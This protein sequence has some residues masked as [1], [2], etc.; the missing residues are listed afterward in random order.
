MSELIRVRKVGSLWPDG[1]FEMC[2]LEGGPFNEK[3]FYY[4]TKEQLEMAY[5]E[6]GKALMKKQGLGKSK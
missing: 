1:M 4:F 6:I 5:D 3:Q 2:F